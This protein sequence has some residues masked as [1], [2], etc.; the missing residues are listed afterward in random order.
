MAD[1]QYPDDR[2]GPDG[3]VEPDQNDNSTPFGVPSTST[4]AVESRTDGPGR[5]PE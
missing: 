1:V 5:D 3:M 4:E 2:E